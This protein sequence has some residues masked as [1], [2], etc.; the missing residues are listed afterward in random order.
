MTLIPALGQLQYWLALWTIVF[1]AAGLWFCRRELWNPIDPVLLLMLNIA[2]NV[3]VVVVLGAAS[4]PGAVLFVV[5]GFALFLGGLARGAAPPARDDSDARALGPSPAVTRLSLICIALA[6]VGYDVFVVQQI[7]LGI[8]GGAN[9][10]IVKVTLTQGGNGLFRY[11]LVGANLFFLPLLLHSLFVCRL[12]W[13]FSVALMF[14]IAQNMVF[15]FS[16]AGFVFDFANLGILAFY[17]R[18]AFGRQIVPMKFVGYIVVLGGI[19]ALIVLSAL[20]AKY[21]LGIGSILVGRVIATASGSYMYFNLGGSH[22]FDGIDVIAR[23][24]LYL[25][26]VLAPLRLKPW[27]P[28]SYSAQVGEFLTGTSLPGFGA[29][30][31]LFVSADFL[32]GWWGL[33]YCYACGRLLRFARHRKTNVVAF[34]VGVQLALYIP[35]DPGIAETAIV[36]LL[37][38]A[39]LW[40]VFHLMAV[41]QARKLSWRIVDT[42]SGWGAPT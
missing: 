12:R 19:P 41:S 6:Y 27:A 15:G 16:K 42:A 9:P 39:P 31:Y 18:R 32:F 35:A 13:T 28:S 26:N 2:L 11:V 37:L 22:A 38:F 24:G 40:A 17:Y 10:D 7:G 30:P 8:L 3:A 14:Y 21:D 29:N 36:A 1:F 34:Y 5:V 23:L 33:L 20:A 4:A 25:D